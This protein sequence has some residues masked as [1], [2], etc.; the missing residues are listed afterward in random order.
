MTEDAAGVDKFC[1]AANCVVSLLPAT[2]HTSIAQSCI[3]RATLLVIA[4]YI[5]PEMKE[6]DT[7]AK[8]AGILISC[9]MNLGPSMDYMSMIKVIDEVDVRSGKIVSLSSI[10]GG[11]PALEAVD[12]AIG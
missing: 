4:S 7:K 11:L 12:K 1:A 6:P 8:K 2:M 3:H 10:C 9:K 5:A